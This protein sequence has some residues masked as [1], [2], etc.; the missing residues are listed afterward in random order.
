MIR[1]AWRLAILFATSETHVFVLLALPVPKLKACENTML[2]MH[3]LLIMTLHGLLKTKTK[4][5]AVLVL[6]PEIPSVLKICQRNFYRCFKWNA[7]L[8]N[9]DMRRRLREGRR[10]FSLCFSLLKG[11]LWCS[12]LWW[13]AFIPKSF[14]VDVHF[15]AH[16]IKIKLALRIRWSKKN[17]KCDCSSK[18]NM[19]I[20]WH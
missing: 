1:R 5:E 20:R 9:E 3:I 6:S 8:S 12:Q 2:V 11:V 7:H 16:E 13:T 15:H 19:C 10:T 17:S 4:K 18:K 14:A